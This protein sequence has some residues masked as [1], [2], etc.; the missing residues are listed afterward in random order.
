MFAQHNTKYINDQPIE[1]ML[2]II[3]TKVL[4]ESYW[5]SVEAVRVNQL[6]PQMSI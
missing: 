3:V 1:E 6:K 2:D 5:L 4:Y